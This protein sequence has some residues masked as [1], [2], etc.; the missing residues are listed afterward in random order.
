VEKLIESKAIR[1]LLFVLIL[2]AFQFGSLRTGF[3]RPFRLSK[4]P[5]NG[6]NF[7]CASC[8]IDAR[9]GGGRNAFGRDFFKHGVPNGN[10]YTEELG[11]LDSDGDGFTNDEE[12]AAKTHPG[13]PN[14]RP[15]K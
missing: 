7:G 6:K 5:D 11:N 1:N 14:S 10:R 9:G 2:F 4:I 8:H 12:F 3:G 13:D 15:S